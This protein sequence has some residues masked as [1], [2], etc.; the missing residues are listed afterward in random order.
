LEDNFHG[1][2]ELSHASVPDEDAEFRRA[3]FDIPVP[4]VSRRTIVRIRQLTLT[5]FS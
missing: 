1:F 2:G 4:L 3:A 5:L